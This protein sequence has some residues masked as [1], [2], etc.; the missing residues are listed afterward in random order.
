M[1][2][3]REQLPRALPCFPWSLDREERQD[4]GDSLWGARATPVTASENR[5]LDKLRDE[6]TGWA[7]CIP[8]RAWVR[9]WELHSSWEFR[10]KQKKAV[11]ST[12]IVVLED[13]KE[14]ARDQIS[15]SRKNNQQDTHSGPWPWFKA[16]TAEPLVVLPS[17]TAGSPCEVGC[18][19]VLMMASLSEINARIVCV[20]LP[21][22]I[23]C[24]M[25]MCR[26]F[27]PASQWHSSYKIYLFYVF[28]ALSDTYQRPFHASTMHNIF[29]NRL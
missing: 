1:P 15:I 2:A 9:I 24:D 19:D 7:C 12:H 22:I 11:Y 29:C 18:V 13:G 3:C 25:K 6:A 23:P 5:H 10:G 27:F 16:L 14:E 20:E 26:R 8:Q 17:S 4:E 28:E 21:F